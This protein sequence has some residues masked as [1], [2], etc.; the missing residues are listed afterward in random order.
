MASNVQVTIG[1]S[2][3]TVITTS[4]GQIQCRV[5]AQGSNTSP[6][7]VRVTSHGVTVTSSVSFTYDASST[8]VVSSISP[9]SGF[10]GQ[11][12][13]ISG[14]NF[15]VGQSSVT[16]GGSTCVIATVSSSTVTC[17]L[18]SNTAGSQPVVVMINSVG[19]SNSNIQFSYS[20]QVTSASP[21]VGSYGGG[22][23][24]TITGN[25]FNSTGIS[26][27]ICNQACQ[28]VSVISTTQLAC[29]TPAATA[30][31]SDQV[32]S[33]TVSM[34]GTSQSITYTYRA[35]LTA[36]VASISPTR[37]GTGGGTTLTITGIN[38]P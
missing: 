33:L 37:G 7:T 1:S 23:T 9:T 32:C 6:A 8:P 35:S 30:S 11:T 38:F 15:V 28:S 31:S 22:Q 24:V 25:G 13:T 2:A 36:S 16:V 10:A 20:L 4:P 17:T 29:V 12:L 19:L 21:S 14:S 18:G 34:G 26:V 27:T 5:P 3:C